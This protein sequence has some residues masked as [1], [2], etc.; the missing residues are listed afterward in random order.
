MERD[1]SFDNPFLEIGCVAV[2]PEVG[3]IV[4][5]HDCSDVFYVSIQYLLDYCALWMVVMLAALLAVLDGSL[6]CV[7]H[8]HRL[9]RAFRCLRRLR[10]VPWALC[11]H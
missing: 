8:P 11:P 6:P 9:S 7:F 2:V 1:V 10:C 4:V 3:V 5:K